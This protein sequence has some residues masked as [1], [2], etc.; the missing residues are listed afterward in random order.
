MNVVFC[1][2][3]GD[4]NCTCRLMA[5]GNYTI[6]GCFKYNF[7]FK[8]SFRLKNGERHKGAM[9]SVNIPVARILISAKLKKQLTPLPIIKKGKP[10][11]GE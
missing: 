11:Y 5:A 9:R 3:V 1:F 2:I 10:V 6:S 7:G 8:A 4:F